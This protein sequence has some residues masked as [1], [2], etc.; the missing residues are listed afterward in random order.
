MSQQKSVEDVGSDAVALDLNASTGRGQERR[1]DLPVIFRGPG[2]PHRS[3]K[4]DRFSEAA[5]S[6]YGVFGSISRESHT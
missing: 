6:S 3:A 1:S 2:P 4:Q 5:V